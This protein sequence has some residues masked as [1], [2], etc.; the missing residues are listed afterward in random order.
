MPIVSHYH[1][2]ET[3]A[4]TMCGQEKPLDAYYI[5]DKTTGRRF[6]W[7]K[8]CHLWRTNQR[9]HEKTESKREAKRSAS[10]P[11]RKQCT[12]CGEEKPISEFHRRGDNKG[13]G[14]RSW[15]KACRAIEKAEYRTANR[16]RINAQSAEYREAE[17][18]L[19]MARK[20][21]WM[22][23][24]PDRMREIQRKTRQK[25]AERVRAY[26]QQYQREHKAEYNAYWHARRA[27]KLSNGGSHTA[28]EWELCKA[29]FGHYCLMCGRREPVVKL[30]KDHIVPIALG[31]SDGIENIQPLCQRCNSRKGD[32]IVD[33]RPEWE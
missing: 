29:H 10:K 19:I 11:T 6:S 30:T 1:E 7:C 26:N 16:E 8:D 25:N 3:K 20:D 4:C 27:R 23:E 17:R 32:T 15:C 22:A 12:R 28:A 33:F 24:H 13:D 14:H 5:K 21:Q 9:Y 18:T 31:G 2:P